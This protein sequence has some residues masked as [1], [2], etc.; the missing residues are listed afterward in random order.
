MTVFKFC[1]SE[2]HSWWKVPNPVTINI[3]NNKKKASI[4][5]QL[6]VVLR[7][8]L[9]L[10]SEWGS[11]HG[12]WRH[13]FKYLLTRIHRAIYWN[14]QEKVSEKVLNLNRSFDFRNKQELNKKG[15]PPRQ[16]YHTNMCIGF[17]LNVLLTLSK[18]FIHWTSYSTSHRVS[19]V[20]LL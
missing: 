17:I 18:E 20:Y 5:Q 13:A 4:N 19:Y 3:K 14:C 15:V 16:C 9:Q 8:G 7:K 1:A 10:R 2:N 12:H 6:G 11:I